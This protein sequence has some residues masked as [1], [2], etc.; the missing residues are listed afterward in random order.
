MVHH[1]TSKYFVL[2]DKIQVLIDAG[3]LNLKSE[4]KKV[5][6]NMVT[7]EFG[8]FL[9]VTIP[10]RHAPTPK[11][12]L[13]VI[14]PSTKQQETKGLIP[15]TMKSKEI[16]WVYPDL[17]NDEQWDSKEPKLKAKSC[18]VVSILPDDDNITVASLSDLKTRSMLWWHRTLHLN[19]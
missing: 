3:V 5:T 10:D 8:T 11:A 13:K 15:I 17:T 14:N 1:P 6:V 7:L 19:Q 9:K 12:R 4:Q 18:N 2:K 16:M